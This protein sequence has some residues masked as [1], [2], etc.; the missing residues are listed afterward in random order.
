MS[1]GSESTDRLWRKYKERD[2]VQA[3][4][5]LIVHYAPLVRQVAGRVAVGLPPSVDP[6]DLHGYGIFGLMDAV[7]KFEPERGIKFETYAQA[8]IR[9][10]MIDG[11]RSDDWVPRS[12][13]QK[14]RELD[15][16]VGKLEAE[17]GRSATDDEIRRELGLTKAEYDALLVDVRGASLV[18]LDDLLGQDADG[19]APLRLG[20]LVKDEGTPEPGA[21][22][23][24]EEVVRLLAEAIDDLP[25][26]ERLIVTMYYYEELTLKEIGHVLGVSESRISQLHSRSMTRLR[27]RLQRLRDALVG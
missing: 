25:E 7:D 2:S 24:A 21:A 8:R 3:R 14:A 23:E 26:R 12:V 20:Q 10:A 18:S 19:E 15:R 16:A 6:D 4:E 11:L 27:G 22:F 1:V 13:R 17:L 9:G 5:Q